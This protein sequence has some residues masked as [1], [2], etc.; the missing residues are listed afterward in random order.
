MRSQLL[1]L[2]AFVAAMATA[3]SVGTV[4]LGEPADW[5][6]EAKKLGLKEAQVERLARDKVLMT[7]QTFRQVFEPYRAVHRTTL[8]VPVFITTDAVLNAYHALL[9][10]SVLWMEVANARRLPGVLRQLS[11]AISKID[12]RCAEGPQLVDNAHG[13]LRLVL[14]VALRLLDERSSAAAGADQKAIETE[15]RRVVRAKER[16]LP[17]WLAGGDRLICLDY[18]ASRN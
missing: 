2:A 9:E 1:G 15:V 12:V 6:V 5:R 10:E 3:I 11:E 17:D 14:G 8:H 7:N 18:T 4:E 13:R 16:L